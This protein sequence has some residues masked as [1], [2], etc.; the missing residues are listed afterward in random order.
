MP[1]LQTGEWTKQYIDGEWC[2]ASTG[3]TSAIEN[4][5]NRETF[6]EVPAA[7]E[8]DVDRAY[9]SAAA[10]QE[11]WADRP[12]EDRVAIIE[13][14]IEAVE[15]AR[16]DIVD[17]LAVESGKVWLVSAVEIE[18]TLDQMEVASTLRLEE[19]QPESAQA[20][21]SNVVKRQPVGVIG[22]ITPWNF[23]LY[24]SM[25]A[26]APALALG[27]AVVLKPALE[28]PITGG[29]LIAR[30]F[31]QAGLPPGLL[32]VVTGS[33]SDIG[34][35]ITTHEIPRVISFTGS[36][37][38]G[39]QVAKSAAANFSYPGLELGG[40]NPHIVTEHADLDLAASAGAF[41]TFIH[42][43][44]I[45]IS[46][47]RHLVHETLY[48][49]YVD[50]VAEAAEGLTMGD[51]GE[52]RNELGPVATEQQRDEIVEFIDSAVDAGASLETGGDYDGLFVEPTV[53]SDATNEMSVS[54][55]EHFGPIA[56]I[57]PFETVDEAI[58]MAN[59]TQYGLSASVHSQDGDQAQLIADSLETGMVHIN[60]Q[61][62]NVGT[63]EPFGGVKHSGLGRFNGEWIVDEFT[64]PKWVSKQ[65]EPR[66]YMLF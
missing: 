32:N 66:D 8:A 19:E 1:S 51:P 26:V 9:Q 6:T 57:I 17:L 18:S 47:N 61:P 40:N 36:E 14:A 16:N 42:Q 27:N 46:I 56:P 35:S 15:D 63:I 10:A 60:D 38:V 7:T 11:D 41:G 33:G 24:L 37:E 12:H 53:L 39:K 43:G 31:E 49:D 5:A 4:P 22:V 62:A 20:N 52:S 65:E 34:N 29:L 3:E 21:K 54:C 23:P 30:L 45:C 2:G 13:D 55:N 59:A 50:Q 44:Q 58:E 28:T 64:E 25:R 48:D